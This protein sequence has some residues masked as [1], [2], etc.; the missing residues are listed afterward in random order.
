MPQ[1][2]T[3]QKKLI[4]LIERYELH[5]Y[6]D[7]VLNGRRKSRRKQR[8]VELVEPKEV[9][10]TYIVQQGDT[11]YSLSRKFGVTVEELKS[12]NNLK[13]NTINIGQPLKVRKK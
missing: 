4:G 3:I 10:E 6:D 12:M 1:T 2:A 13:N 9:Y 8:S 11:L 7:E 5:K